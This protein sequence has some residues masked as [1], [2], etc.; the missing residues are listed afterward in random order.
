MLFEILVVIDKC[1]I[2]SGRFSIIDLFKV[3]YVNYC[4]LFYFREDSWF[5]LY[6]IDGSFLWLCKDFL[7]C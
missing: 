3:Y 1:L 7:N 4:S 6:Y 2:M 5:G